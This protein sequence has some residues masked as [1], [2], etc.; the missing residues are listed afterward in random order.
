MMKSMRFGERCSVAF[1][2]NFERRNGSLVFFFCGAEGGVVTDLP[3]LPPRS[4]SVKT[5]S[6]RSFL[7]GGGESPPSGVQS[8]F[9][10]LGVCSSSCSLG[11]GVLAWGLNLF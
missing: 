4:S 7:A 6:M 10:R 11:G 3:V 5:R 8:R 1:L 9:F 2:H